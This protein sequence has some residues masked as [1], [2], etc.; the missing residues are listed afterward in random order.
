MIAGKS[1]VNSCL[2]FQGAIHVLL[3][4]YMHKCTSTCTCTSMENKSK[5]SFII[6]IWLIKYLK[7]SLCV[8]VFI[9]QT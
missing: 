9:Y 5:Y 7:E 4:L 6:K 8:S 2:S 1:K 3:M